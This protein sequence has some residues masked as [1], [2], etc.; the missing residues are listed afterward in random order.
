MLRDWPADDSAVATEASVYDL[1]PVAST[2][3]AIEY[4]QKSSGFPLITLSRIWFRC[5][6]HQGK[7][8]NSVIPPE[9]RFGKTAGIQPQCDGGGRKD[10]QW[11]SAAVEICCTALVVESVAGHFPLRNHQ[12]D[13]NNGGPFTSFTIACGSP[14][15]NIL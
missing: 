7:H 15:I 13:S 4:L 12:N 9:T 11:D 10:Y 2:Q 14:K 6:S 8:K 1:Q 3:A 5:Y